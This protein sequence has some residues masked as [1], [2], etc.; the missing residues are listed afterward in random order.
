MTQYDFIRLDRGGP[1]YDDLLNAWREEAEELGEDFEIFSDIPVSVFQQI[2]E[3][4]GPNTALYAA[5][6]NDGSFGAVCMLNHARI[7]GYDGPVLRVRH[8]LLSPKFDLTDMPLSEYSDVLFTILSG[9]I[10][11]SDDDATLRANHIKFHLRS[12]ADVQFF[13]AVGKQLSGAQIYRSVQSR[14]SWLYIT[15]E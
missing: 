6:S 13:A 10:V 8:I 11:Y 15:K 9:V 5:Q 7:P 3:K 4:D 12:P 14:G 2:T 1:T